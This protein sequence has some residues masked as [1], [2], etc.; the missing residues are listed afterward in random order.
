MAD[1]ARKLDA[2]HEC[3]VRKMVRAGRMEPLIAAA[4]KLEARA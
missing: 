1:A 4:M 2:G 3:T